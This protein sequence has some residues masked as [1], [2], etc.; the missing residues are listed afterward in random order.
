VEENDEVEVEVE[1]RPEKEEE[2]LGKALPKD[3]SDT[4]LLTFPRRAKKHVEDKKFSYFMEVIQRMYVHILMIDAMQVWTYARYLKDILNQSDQY[5][6]WSG[7]CLWKDVVLLS[8]MVLLIRWVT[9][10]FQPSLV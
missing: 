10:V 6:R 2:N 1:M 7:S 8:L 3:I 5:P 9:Q 4:H